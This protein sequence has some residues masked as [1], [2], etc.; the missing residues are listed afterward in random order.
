VTTPE[1][2]ALLKQE[3]QLAVL[4]GHRHVDVSVDLL[5]GF[6]DLF[7]ANVPAP[8]CEE[9]HVVDW[10]C[11]ECEYKDDTIADLRD[12]VDELQTQ[13]KTAREALS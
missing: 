5:L 6:I 10:D 13:I 8:K 9:D 7:E 11:G 12:L 2:V 1:D 4:R 3:A